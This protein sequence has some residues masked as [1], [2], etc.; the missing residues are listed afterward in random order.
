MDTEV[1]NFGF[2]S[3]GFVLNFGFSALADLPLA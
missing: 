1:L 3:F 2:W